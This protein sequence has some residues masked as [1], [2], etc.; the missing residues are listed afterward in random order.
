MTKMIVKTTGPFQLVDVHGGGH[1][2]AGIASLVDVNNFFQHRIGL[3]QLDVIATNFP[4]DATDAEFQSVVAAADGDLV[5]AVESYR[6]ELAAR[7]TPPE[8]APTKLSKKE[9]Q[10]AEAAARAAAGGAG[11]PGSSGAAGG[12][13]TGGPGGGAATGAGGGDS[14]LPGGGAA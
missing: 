13:A 5:L 7:L 2:R 9:R 6:A 8:P 4:D 11:D 10:A 14:G 3:G 1:A 12:S